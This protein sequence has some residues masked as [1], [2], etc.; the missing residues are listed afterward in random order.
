MKLLLA[1]LVALAFT[2]CAPDFS[3]PSLRPVLIKLSEPAKVGETV[4]L[5]GRYLGSK[6]N[7]V[8]LFNADSSGAT[9]VSSAGTDVVSWS[10]SEIQ[11]RVPLNVR[12]GGNFIFVSVGGVLSNGMVYSITK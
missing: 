2:S 9:G 3:R 10:A 7:G 6:E 11:V 5:Q 8:V 1:G 4:S 12:P